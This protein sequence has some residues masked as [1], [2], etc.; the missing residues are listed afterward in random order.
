M[1]VFIEHVQKWEMM[2]KSLS[3][4]DRYL[5]DVNGKTADLK[6]S[7]SCSRFIYILAVFNLFL[8]IERICACMFV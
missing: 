4:I 8:H 6:T 1:S 7:T 3:D 5:I 2:Y